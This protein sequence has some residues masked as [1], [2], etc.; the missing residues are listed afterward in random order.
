MLLFLLRTR[1]C[2][3]GATSMPLAF[4]IFLETSS[5]NVSRI[6]HKTY[7]R[8]HL[9]TLG[10]RIAKIVVSFSMFKLDGWPHDISFRAIGQ[11]EK[12]LGGAHWGNT[13]MLG[14]TANLKFFRNLGQRLGQ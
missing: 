3:I 9:A 4:H 6:E 11:I 10:I 1:N 2:V 5:W 7:L 13:E 8:H 14:M 12:K